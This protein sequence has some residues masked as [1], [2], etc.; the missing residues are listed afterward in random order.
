VVNELLRFDG[1]NV[2]KYEN[3]CLANGVANAVEKLHNVWTTE[4]CLKDFG[5][6]E[7]FFSSDRL[8]NFEHALLVVSNTAAF[9]HFRVLSAS[10]FVDDL[11]VLQ[12]SPIDVELSIKRVFL[13]SVSTH[14]LIRTF[15]SCGSL[16]RGYR[17]LRPA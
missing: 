13:R 4:E 11:V 2:L 6:A 17:R 8:Q 1:R 7:D 10:K 12:V 5:L 14:R 16:L 15:E 3:G 9:E